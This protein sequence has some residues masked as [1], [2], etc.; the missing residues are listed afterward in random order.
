MGSKWS[1]LIYNFFIL[2]IMKD[3]IKN[4]NKEMELGYYADDLIEIC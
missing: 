4:N 3:F 2:I 1:P